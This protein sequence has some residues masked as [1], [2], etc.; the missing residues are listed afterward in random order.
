MREKRIGY[1]ENRNGD[2]I[3][4]SAIKTKDIIRDDWVCSR[5][6]KAME[7]QSRVDE[8]IQDTLKGMDEL[9][10]LLA[11]EYGVELKESRKGN[12]SITSYDGKIKVER[13]VRDITTFD[14]QIHIAKQLI[15]EC[16]IDWTAEGRDEIKVIVQNAFRV[17]K[18][19]RMNMR[20]IKGLRQYEFTDQRW[21][22]AMEIIADSETALKSKTSLSIYRRPSSESDWQKVF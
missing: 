3:P 13:D 11:Q 10:E 1:K 2:F 14:E 9:E 12:R 15:D 6:E 4:I 18:R 16:L 21:V 17:D 7:L 5:A 19:G 22:K 20:D 8:F